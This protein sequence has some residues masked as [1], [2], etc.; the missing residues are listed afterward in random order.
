MVA[1]QKPDLLEEQPEGP[2]YLHCNH[3]TKLRCIRRARA[4]CPLQLLDVAASTTHPL[5]IISL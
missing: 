5:L 3:T 1:P 4:V 2:V